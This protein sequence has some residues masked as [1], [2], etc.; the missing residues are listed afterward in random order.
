VKSALTWL[1]FRW[2]REVT[3]EQ[4]M[5]LTRL[6][7]SAGGTPL[8]IEAVGSAAHVEHR[9]ALP[10]GYAESLID[11][12][13][14][15]LPGVAIESVNER[16]TIHVRRM[17]ELRLT[18]RLRPL[19]EDITNSSRA[20]LTAL[21]QTHKHEYLTLQWVLVRRLPSSSV[22]SQVKGLSRESWWGALLLAPLSPPPPLDANVEAV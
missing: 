9:L 8:V 20:R 17:V 2:P 4:A 15:A 5:Q 19:D 11:Q 6:L 21:A 1:T 10:S 22:P 7:A 12:L 16:P 13:R 18:T 3:P 14:A